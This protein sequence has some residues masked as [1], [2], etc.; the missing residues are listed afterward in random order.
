MNKA[1]CVRLLV[2]LVLGLTAGNAL[3]QRQV[4]DKVVAIVDEGVVLQS[5]LDTRLTEAREQMGGWPA[6]ATRRA[7][8]RTGAGIPGGGKPADAAGGAHGHPL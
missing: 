3:A 6:R 1:F 4:L 7:A 8:A 5:E 2:I